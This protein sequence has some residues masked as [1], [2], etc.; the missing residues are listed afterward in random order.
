MVPRV[1]PSQATRNRPRS[2]GPRTTRTDQVV[3]SVPVRCE[4]PKCHSGI[5]GRRLSKTCSL[6]SLGYPSSCARWR[7]RDR[8]EEEPRRRHSVFLGF[9]VETGLFGP[10]T[11]RS[12]QE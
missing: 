10:G 9:P 2:R 11:S 6:R 3:Q 5:A 12:S 1:V 4:S 7:R 8:T